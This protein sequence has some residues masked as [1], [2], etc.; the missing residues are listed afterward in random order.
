MSKIS[1]GFSVIINKKNIILNL[2]SEIN[3]KIKYL[4]DLYIKLVTNN[5][6][7]NNNNNDNNND[8]LD[9]ITTDSFYFQI[10]LIK[11]QL[12]NYQNIFDFINNQIYSD[13]YKLIKFIEKYINNNFDTSEDSEITTVVKK[14]VPYKIKDISNNYTI[15][16]SEK[17]YTN[18][19]DSI[20]TLIQILDN[21][22]KELYSTQKSFNTG[23]DIDNFLETIKFNNLSIQHNINLFTNF[24]N[25]YTKYHLS[26]LNN[27]IKNLQILYTDITNNIFFDKQIIDSNQ[28]INKLIDNKLI[29]NKLIDNKLI[30]NKL[31]DNK[32][33]DISKLCNYKLK[34]F[35]GFI[36]INLFSLIYYQKS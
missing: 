9:T 14:F 29:D 8:K 3:E 30:N 26:Y 16:Y 27:L 24:L 13:Y 10:K 6:N 11:S 12:N 23:I 19:V 22:N 34:Y 7:N 35:I 5:N 33:I 18:I 31:I 2:I 32:L 4:M 1:N 20:N 15:T 17:I 28:I 21:S 36:L 25:G